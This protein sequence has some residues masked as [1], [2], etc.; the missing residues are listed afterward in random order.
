MTL[1]QAESALIELNPQ[2]FYVPLGKWA[3][4]V[5]GA[6]TGMSARHWIFAGPRS[7]IGATLRGAKPQRVLNP[8]DGAKPYKI[9]PSSH[10]PARRALHAVGSALAT[11]QPTLCILGDAALASGEFHQALSVS[12]QYQCPTTF[13]VIRHPLTDDAPVSKQYTTSIKSIAQSLG[14]QY[15]H[16]S[17][18]KETIET[19]VQHAAES[20]L[21]YLIETT[22][23]K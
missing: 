17:A 5:E 15:Q 2:P 20:L 7:R 19:A 6:F 18:Q 3:P 4:I 16:V 9:A 14:M 23:E 11:R 10:H 8:E 1:E 22:L 13:L 21:P 12:V